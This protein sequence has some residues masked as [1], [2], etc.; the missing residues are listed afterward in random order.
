M[1]LRFMSHD[2]I[3]LDLDELRRLSLLTAACAE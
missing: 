3:P 2:E 1:H